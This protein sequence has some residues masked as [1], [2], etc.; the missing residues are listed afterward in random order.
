MPG[1]VRRP[2]D[3]LRLALALL[4]IVLILLFAS[5]AVTTTSGLE[6]DLIGRATGLPQIVLRTLTIAGE[7]GLLLIPLAVSADLLIRR[8]PGQVA[9]ALLAAA[10]AA[11]LAYGVRLLVE[12]FEPGQ[13]LEAMT[14]VLPNGQRTLLLSASL[15]AVVALLT[16]AQLAGRPRWQILS[17]L[18]VVSVA[19]TTVLSNSMTLVASIASILVGWSV[20]LAA[21]Y[22][23]GTPSERPDGHAVAAALSRISLPMARLQRIDDAAQGRRRYLGHT[24]DGRDLTIDVLD[25]DQEGAGIFAYLWRS[26]RVIRPASRPTYLSLRRTMEHEGLVTYAAMAA[27]VPVVPLLGMTEI[28]SD[29]AVLAY[30]YTDLPSLRT[31]LDDDGHASLTDVQ[32]RAMWRTLA[33]MH[34]ARIA[35]RSLVPARILIGTD[36]ALVRELRFGEVAASDFTLDIDVA[37]LLTTT[38]SAVGVERAVR[39]ADATIGA[40]RLGRAL[41]LLQTLSM[42]TTTRRMLRGRKKLLS[43]LREAVDQLVP[44]EPVEQPSLRRF[45]PRTVF[46]AVGLALAAYLLVP[47]L[48]SV[49]FVEIA[50]DA[51]W[52]WAA[53]PV[54]LSGLTYV[55]A[56]MSLIG[57]TPHKLKVLPTVMAQY[58]VTYFGLFAP[59]LVSGVAINTMYLQRSGVYSGV[60]VASVG[61]SQ[62]SAV[63]ASVLMIITFGALAGTGPQASFTPSEGVLLAIALVVAVVIIALGIGP[64]RRL[65]VSRVRPVFSRV[66]PRL[67]DVLQSPKALLIGFSGNVLMN[68]G[69]IFAMVASVRAFGGELGIPTIALVLLA[70]VAVGSAVP[71]PGGI[72]AIEAALTAGLT[73]AGLDGGTALSAVLLYRIATFWI[74]IPC[75]FVCQNLLTKRGLLFAST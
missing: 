28:G 13:V 29:A 74:P 7:L 44:A 4:A 73:A 19:V 72:G 11:F 2:R 42:S 59:S 36:V 21:R 40:H 66:I 12:R 16:V 43:E 64:I 8:R 38:A 34:R 70:G 63:L 33:A 35:H 18:V 56:A 20:G 31:Q 26:L 32:L 10:A 53:V 48:S 75:G 6:Q 51:D 14:K 52:H 69:F 45:K 50:Q 15:S 3:L 41:P 71:T 49:D 25:R 58:A 68:I 62:L 17:T 54:L 27:D 46:S 67:L 24:T 57:F 61:V 5:L 39:A 23:R 47:Q 1:T 37:E 22:L 30:T 55:G 60:A 65:I 9:T